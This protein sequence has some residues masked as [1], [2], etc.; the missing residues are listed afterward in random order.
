[1]K[2]TFDNMT[3]TEFSHAKES[4]SN[5]TK[6]AEHAAA[7]SGYQITPSQVET[8]EYEAGGKAFDKIAA[9]TD[10]NSLKYNT[11]KLVVLSHTMSEESYSSYLKDGELKDVK[12]ED[13]VNIMDRIKM[14]LVKGGTVIDGFT[15]DLPKELK[16]EVKQ[17]EEKAAELTE[18]TEGM[19]RSLVSTGNEP[20]IDNLYLAKF[21][22]GGDRTG[23]SGSYF[24]IEAPGYL[25]KKAVPVDEAELKA[26]VTELLKS[27]TGMEPDEES[28]EAGVWLVKNS[29]MVNEENIENYKRAESVVLPV[30]PEQL[31]K[32]IGIALVEGKNPKD[33]DLTRTESIY[34]EAVRITDDILKMSDAEVHAARVFE[35][36]RLKMTT[37][38]NLLLIKSGFSI[39]TKDL[40]AY[41]EALRKIEN[42]AEYKE[43][44]AVSEVKETIEEIKTLPAAVIGRMM[45]TIPDADLLTIREEG[46][47]IRETFDT[48]MEKYEQVST[49]VRPDLGDSIKKAFG[50]VDDIL[51]EEGLEVTDSNRRAVRILGYN[52]MP[53]DEKSI[54]QVRELDIKL[55]H[56][57]KA[58]TPKDTLDLIRKGTSPVRMS[59]EELTDY[60]SE[61]ESTNEEKMEKYS[62][63]LYKLERSDQITQQEREQYIEVYRLL[64]QLEKTGYAAIGGLIKT[65]RDLTFGNLK[66]EIKTAKHIG[67]D[68][69]IDESFGFLVTELEDKLSPDTM[70]ITNISDDTSLYR[71][72]DSV[73]NEPADEVL[74]Q[75]YE[76][77]MFNREF[78][79]G[80]E[81]SDASIIELLSNNEPVTISNLTGMELLIR[82]RGRAFKKVDEIRG[83]DFRDEID[84][85]SDDF[86]EEEKAHEDYMKMADN[87]K[88]AV[89][90][91]AMASDSYIDV[92]E[93]TLTH[94][95]L[96]LAADLSR[97]ETYNVPMEIDGEM[98]DVM[99]KI[100]HNEKEEPS[101]AVSIDTEMLGR[102]SARFTID[103]GKTSGYIACNY[104][105][106][107]TKL[108]K[109]A[110]IMGDG[111]SVIHTRDTDRDFAF[112]KLSVKDNSKRVSSEELYK[113][114]KR[115]LKSI[116]D[117][118]ED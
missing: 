61:K 83:K 97:E 47:K 7:Y 87:S 5:Q 44:K 57:I 68:I 34:E 79:T 86:D 112:S 99:L 100:V 8:T 60:L 89:F 52:S 118:N 108:Q 81:A 2:I 102:V 12:P 29:F 42:T 63:F 109:V 116:G 36:V 106:S 1:M 76:R 9:A 92:K 53:I 80:L 90:E 39:D 85:L 46:S 32:A 15:D 22:D 115:F 48:A 14:E 69:K 105:E 62:K 45:T 78:R 73:V 30:S 35:E 4:V 6:V 21:S 40:E 101:V 84:E 51:T 93:L 113:T 19:V 104:E 96:S 27:E 37:E 20:T 54:A 111:I 25:A 67:S 26:Q 43:A 31:K 41:V 88:E 13:A 65:G 98:T 64:H 24:S 75:E 114:A 17:A 107:V 55:N 95:Q 71:A 77:E 16:R 10:A 94:K 103:D 74:E 23:A 50:N 33:A 72:Y 70:K 3:H 117:T 66:E 58:L 38:A 82:Q 59:V 28:I 49:E 110:D 56:V 91:R 18:M 11:D